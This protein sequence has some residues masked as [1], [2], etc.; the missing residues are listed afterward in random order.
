MMSLKLIRPYSQFTNNK[1]AN[2]IRNEFL[3]YF[4]KDLKHDIV[5]SS[6]VAPI[7]DHSLAFI[8]AG[9]NQF[10]GVFLNYY[11]PPA[12]RVANS[13]KCI[14]VGG[15]HNDLSVVGNDS[16]HHT[17]F[18]MLGN[19]SFGD[20]FK[21]EACSYAWNLLTN[22]Y[23]IPK[24]Y[25][26]VTY[27]G[28]DEKLGMSPD[29]ECKDIWLRLGLPECKVL[30]FGMR[31]NFWEMGVSG[32]CGPCTEI[33]V[34]Y[35]KRAANQAERVNKG[36]ADLMELWNIVFIQYE[37]LANG[38]IVPLP[39]H[40]VD[41][42]MGL[43][44]LV[45]LLQG[46]TSNYDTDLFQPLFDAIRKCSNAPE[47][48]GTFDN[49]DIGKIDYGYRILADHA[50]MVTVALADNMLPEQHPKLRKILRHAIDVGEK[51][52]NRSGIIS[53]LT[54]NVADNL[55]IVYPELHSNLKQVQR[56]IDF[57]EDLFK[58]LRKTS[59]KIWSKMVET[60]PELAAITDWMAAGLVDGY[61]DLQSMLKELRKMNVLPGTVAF[62]LYD[63]YGLSSETIAE[64]AQIESLYFDE[65]DFEKQLDN[66]RYQ[67]R[68]GLDKHSTVL[69]K[70]SLGI[71][72]KNHVP[73]TDD[74][75]KYNYTYNGNN[76]IFPTINSKL[77]GIVINGELIA[78]KNCADITKVNNIDNKIILNIDE[79][80][81]DTNKIGIIL[82]KTVCYSLEGG[83]V[84][85]KGNILIKNLLFNIDNIRKINGYVIHSGHF[86][87]TDLP[88]SELHLQIEDDC[89][90]NIE[91]NIRVGAMKH[92]TAAHLLNAALK[93]VMQVIYQRG[94]TV[95]T[96]SLKFQFNSF[97]EQLTSKQM[98]TIEDCINNVIQSQV[99]TMVQTLNLF[100][101]LKQNDVTLIPGEVYPYTNIRVVEINADN[102]KAKET[103]CGTHVHNTSVLQHF[104]FLTY[105]SKGATKRTVKAI[106]GP[107]A[108]RMKQAGEKICQ[109]ITE[110][111][112]SLQS[113]TFTYDLLNAEINRIK[114]EINNQNIQI[115][116][117]YLIKEKCL[118]HLENLSKTVWLRAKEIE[119]DSVIR[120][121]S[122][123]TNSS[124]FIVHCLNK[125]PLFLSL[126]EIISL[127]SGIP[128]LVL[129]YTNEFVKARCSIPQEMT[130]TAFNAQ[131]WMDIVLQIF[132]A[133]HGPIKGFKPSLVASMKSTKVSQDFQIHMEK[134]IIEATK[135]A[136][137]HVK[138]VSISNKKQ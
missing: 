98:K 47:Y 138:K 105:T 39:K 74:S 103:C 31:D 91:P 36:Y 21:E 62:K 96:D 106:V 73:K 55:S 107:Q 87:K 53:K 132:N 8:N 80:L 52:F 57:E 27:F 12:T 22:V 56:I 33:H 67:S 102:L 9:M 76:Y 92:H 81:N 124:C 75:F 46:K 60:R 119:K 42:G 123:A 69:T 94:C 118:T 7:S 59:G 129:S 19:W 45:T 131:T 64:L 66:R 72:E 34:D 11:K 24:E 49:D 14:R 3:D 130:S 83:Q 38:Y 10:K 40:H 114:Q 13:Q 5:R 112:D 128:I 110:L 63:T 93:Q 89:I 82:D 65:I 95:D 51:V 99:T 29:L 68:I 15:K 134:A 109:R 113:D 97:G 30:P 1:P 28:G 25:L 6:P 133:E 41:T 135:F 90:V 115:Q 79:I 77:I 111:E 78:N 23:N 126:H 18:E 16:Y 108:L 88:I 101:L 20:Y 136:S 86:A 125:N 44:R 50:R 35:M 85:D 120:E 26:Y 127:F 117:P 54:C 121:I 43:E 48:K 17:F 4:S 61:K 37:R 84:S 70:E 58:R 116:L 122:D 2:L 71:L 32:P 100:E 104:C 137:I